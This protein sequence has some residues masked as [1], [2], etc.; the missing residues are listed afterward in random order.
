MTNESAARPTGSGFDRRAL[1]RGAAVAAAASVPFQALAARTAAA[2]PAK[3]E[4]DAGY[5]PLRPVRDQATGLELLQ[6]PRGFEYIS[7]GWTNDPMDDGVPT[8]GAH[9]G[10]AA[11]RYGDRV[12]LVRNHE[13]GAGTAFTAPAYDPAAGGGTTTLVFDP[14][15]GRWLESYGSLGG[16]LR[17]CAGGPTPWNTWLTCEETFSTNA[18]KRHG[19]VFEVASQGKGNP[20]PYR[21]MGRFNHE[22]VA[23]DPVTGYVYETEDR[24]DASLY[25]FVPAV[26]G[27]LSRGGRLEAL[28][29]GTGRY[30]TRGDGEKAYGTVSWVPVED[31]DPAEDTV[32]FQAQAN[33]AAVFSRLE[34]AWY[35]NDRIYVITTDG[36]PARQGQVFELDPA[37]DEFRVLF[38]SPGAEVLNAP[39]NMCVSPRGGLVLCEDGGGTEYVHGLTTGGE[40]FRFAANNVDLRAG[41][42]GKAVAAA[43]HRG[44]EWAARSSSPRT[45]TGCS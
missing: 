22:A 6:L 5:G 44:S 41:T 2:A 37:T 3:L 29:I 7:Y 45:A 40:I 24:G 18:G 20:E 8:P 9:D 28:R 1:L 21:A 38:A 25:R 34:G 26:P 17:N 35:G 32:R 43:D 4:F 15:A 27:D 23:V 11:F 30:D 12:H 33:G 39:D 13:R 19:Y 10:M 31:V 36:G 16:T 14:D 42:A